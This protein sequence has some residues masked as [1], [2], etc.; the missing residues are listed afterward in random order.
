MERYIPEN[1]DLDEILKQHPPDFK[2]HKDYFVFII[3]LLCHSR[4]NNRKF[5][6]SEFINLKAAYIDFFVGNS[7]P[8][9]KYLK[10]NNIFICDD[11][12]IPN[13]KSYGYKFYP[14]FETALKKVPITKYT[15]IKSLKKYYDSKLPK[16]ANIKK[17]INYFNGIE[18]DFEGA[19]AELKNSK[20]NDK[21]EKERSK[22]SLEV[23][24]R[25]VEQINDKKIFFK[26][27]EKG[28]R[29]HTSLTNLKKS[30]RKYVTYNGQKL[31]AW[32]ICNSQLFWEQE[33]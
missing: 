4:I 29:L 10:N 33:Y 19:I 31:M 32:D 16:K 20:D 9:L 21:K 14:E 25:R 2:Y 5:E 12:Y 26:V 13:K 15:L 28:N 22:H 24:I 27:D 1:I 23:N 6:N 17:L 11:I 30:S 18:I 8:Y 3:S 7:R